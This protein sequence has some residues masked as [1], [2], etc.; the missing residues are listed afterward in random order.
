MMGGR[1]TARKTCDQLGRRAYWHG[2]N[3]DVKCFIAKCSPCAIYHRGEE[4]RPAA[5][6]IVGQ[7]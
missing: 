7:C 3:N 5:T 4:A 1:A 6:D 2:M